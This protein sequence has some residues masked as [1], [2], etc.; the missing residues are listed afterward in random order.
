MNIELAK[1]NDTLYKKSGTLSS[2]MANKYFIALKDLSKKEMKDM[3]A[4]VE[5]DILL[6]RLFT[7]AF[8]NNEMEIC[9]VLIEIFEERKAGKLID[10]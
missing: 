3:L 10:N 7:S 6:D 8:S 4:L 9:T 5:D 2:T 1:L